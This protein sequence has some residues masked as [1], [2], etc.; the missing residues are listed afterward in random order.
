MCREKE[1]RMNSIILKPYLQYCDLLQSF[2]SFILNAF[3]ASEN[4]SN[5]SVAANELHRVKAVAYTS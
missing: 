3:S 5:I 4:I 1:M 2:C